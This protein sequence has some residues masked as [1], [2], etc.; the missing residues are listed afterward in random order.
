[1][2]PVSE[3]DKWQQDWEIENESESLHAGRPPE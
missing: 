1:M 2:L 3:C